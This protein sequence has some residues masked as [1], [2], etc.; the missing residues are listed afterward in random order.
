MTV[1][2]F[3]LMI[4]DALAIKSVAAAADDLQ[5]RAVN[6]DLQV[7]R[8]DARQINLDD[9]PVARSIHVGRRTP[10]TIT[11]TRAPPHRHQTKISLYRFCHI[12]IRMKDESV[13]LSDE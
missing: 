3:E 6:R 1:R 9:P 13:A 5:H 4:R 11:Q 8:Y 7:I 2:D 12:K 10:Q